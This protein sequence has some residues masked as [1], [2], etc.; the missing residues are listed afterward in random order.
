M[1]EANDG[2]EFSFCRDKE[3]LRRAELRQETSSRAVATIIHP[4]D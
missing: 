2:A 4:L 1:A 3:P